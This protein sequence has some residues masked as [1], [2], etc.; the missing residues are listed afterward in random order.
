MLQRDK[1]ATSGGENNPIVQQ[2]NATLRE[3]R[4]NIDNSL[5]TY[6]NQLQ[7]S[8]D[9]MQSRNRQFLG[10]VSRLP[11]KEKMLRAIERQQ[12]IKESH[13]FLAL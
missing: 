8:L 13:T 6:N 3:L 7:V 11:E 9:Q 5:S 12:T 4:A 2:I 1:L 10:R